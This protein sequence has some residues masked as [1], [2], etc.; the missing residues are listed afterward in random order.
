MVLTFIAVDA[1]SIIGMTLEKIL[2]VDDDDGVRSVLFDLL[3]EMGFGVLAVSSLAQAREQA[4]KETFDLILCDV[5]MKDGNGLDFLVELREKNPAQKMMIMTGFASMDSAV[6]GIRIGVSDYLIK[7]IDP[8]MLEAALRR[9]DAVM[10]LEEENRYLRHEIAASPSFEMLPGKSAAMNTVME[11]IKKA[12]PTEATVLIQGESGTG[13]EMI[14]HALYEASSRAD[15]P[16]IKVNC[17][18]IPANLMESEFFGH[19]KGAFTGAVQRRIGRFELAD[20]G[21]ILLDE[22]TEIPPELQVKL[23]R[24][25]QEKEFER[26]GGSKTLRVDV[27]VFA[28]TNR[29]LSEEVKSGRFREDL[30]YRLNVFPVQ[31]PPLRER[32]GDIILLADFFI[33]KFS[34]RHGAKVQSLSSDAQDHLCRYNWPGNV[35]E[36]QN[37]VER[38]VILA[39]Q[40]IQLDPEDLFLPEKN[41]QHDAPM[42]LAEMERRAIQHALQCCNQNRTHAAR[43]LGISLRTL[44]NRLREYRKE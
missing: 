5:R 41:T 31:I 25:L 19:E 29:N 44:R 15:K 30:F 26:V 39:A 35:R 33:Q 3:Q 21:T 24:V 28:T 17:A 10:K 12:A 14:A 42:T 40:K 43:M 9:L 1:I 20:I 36:L 38:A 2:V 13:K 8:S 23:L 37:V 34:R 27:R 4:G 18:A 6:K 16:F 7:P 32:G 11:M 22:I